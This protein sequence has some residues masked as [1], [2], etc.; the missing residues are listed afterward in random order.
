MDDKIAAE[1]RLALSPLKAD[2][3]FW[4]LSRR[5]GQAFF[6]LRITKLSTVAPK[7]AKG[8]LKRELVH[9]LCVLSEP[10]QNDIFLDPFAGSGAI[11]FERATQFPYKKI[12]ANDTDQVA[13]ASLHKKARTFHNFFVT[14]IDALHLSTIEDHSIDK[15]VTDPPWGFFNTLDKSEGDLKFFYAAM[16]EEM[17]RI[18]K[19]EGKIIILTGRKEMIENLIQNYKKYDILVNGKKAAVYLFS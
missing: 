19:P 5:E 4:F 13:I 8:E 11:P 18:I 10:Q 2:W 1:T 14:S 3:E 16:V 6:G 7:T 9:L 12:I 17:K 15:I